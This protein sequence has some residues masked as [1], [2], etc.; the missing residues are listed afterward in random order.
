MV[1]PALGWNP[2]K[3]AH[4]SPFRLRGWGAIL[5]TNVPTPICSGLVSHL[6]PHTPIRHTASVPR[7][8]IAN[9]GKN[10]APSPFGLEPCVPE[11][12]PGNWVGPFLWGP[13]SPPACVLWEGPH[14]R[15]GVAPSACRTHSSPLPGPVPRCLHGPPLLS[16]R[17][18]IGLR[19]SPGRT[20]FRKLW[21]PPW[22][23]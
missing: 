9:S 21:G 22:W 8:P 13:H 12:S 3:C 16:Q 5:Y 1:L 6:S 18:H 11:G 15:V 19:V 7:E 2:A 4:T 17:M 23:P 14:D 20:D 10:P